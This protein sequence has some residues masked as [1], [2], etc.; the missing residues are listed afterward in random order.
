MN[1]SRRY[2]QESTITIKW[3]RQTIFNYNPNKCIAKI[4]MVTKPMEY[5]PMVLSFDNSPEVVI[6]QRKLWFDGNL[7]KEEGI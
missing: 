6:P 5:V 2:Q 1:T 3:I 4:I 7:P